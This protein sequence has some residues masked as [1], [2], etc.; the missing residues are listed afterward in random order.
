MYCPASSKLI[1][2]STTLFMYSE[3]DFV[4]RVDISVELCGEIHTKFKFTGIFTAGCSSTMHSSVGDD[5]V[6]IGLGA[7]DITSMLGWGTIWK[8]LKRHQDNSQ[9]GDSVRVSHNKIDAMHT[10]LSEHLLDT[11]TWVAVLIVACFSRR[12]E[13]TIISQVY[14]PASDSRREGNESV[15]EFAPR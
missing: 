10:V 3:D 6:R 5:P 2:L 9:F 4:T 14:N 12:L 11:F 13:F 1:S 7:L 15:Y 8:K